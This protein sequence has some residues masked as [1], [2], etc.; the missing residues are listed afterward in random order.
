M[1]STMGASIGFVWLLV[2]AYGVGGAIGA[3]TTRSAVCAWASFRAGV[4]QD[5]LYIDGGFPQYDDGSLGN[6]TSSLFEFKYNTPF[7]FHHSRQPDLMKLWLPISLSLW[8]AP[9]Y[10]GG[11][12]FTDDYELYNYG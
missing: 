8:D 7:N 4:V 9:I 10:H 1:V 3:T 6:P 12:M 5:T 11:A 2:S